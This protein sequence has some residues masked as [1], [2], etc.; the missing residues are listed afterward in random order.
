MPLDEQV[1]IPTIDIAVK[2]FSNKL[3]VVI[4]DN[5]KFGNV[6]EVSLEEPSPD[7]EMMAMMEMDLNDANDGSKGDDSQ[8]VNACL[9]LGDKSVQ[10][11]LELFG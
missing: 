10:E 4:S 9:L 7:T 11:Y 3:M 5:D 2:R 1:L 8:E 6:I